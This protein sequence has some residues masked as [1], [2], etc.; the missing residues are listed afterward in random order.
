MPIAPVNDDG[1]VLYY[2]DTGAPSQS[3]DY[4]TLALVHGLIFHSG[5]LYVHIITTSVLT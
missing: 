3:T 2:E 4:T 1:A 5:T